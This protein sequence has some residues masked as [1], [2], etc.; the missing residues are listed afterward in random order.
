MQVSKWG[1]SL[2][3]RIPNAVVEALQLKEGDEVEVTVAGARQL[4]VERD[5][6]REK[7]LESIRRLA[8]PFPPGWKFDREEANKRGTNEASNS[9]A[10]RRAG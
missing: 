8:R 2:A 10:R 1:N 7:A 5:R 4:A 3:I 6:R 9:R